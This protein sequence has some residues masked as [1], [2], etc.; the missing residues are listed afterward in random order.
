MYWHLKVDFSSRVLQVSRTNRVYVYILTIFDRSRLYVR[1]VI[2]I[3]STCVKNLISFNRVFFFYTWT[4]FKRARKTELLVRTSMSLGTDLSI[5]G[6]GIYTVRLRTTFA[7]L[8]L[9]SKKVI[10]VHEAPR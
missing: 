10:P 8:W 5:F 9:S 6:V 2:N 1:I 4:Y 7:R 3:T